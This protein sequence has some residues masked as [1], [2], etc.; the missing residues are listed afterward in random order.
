MGPTIHCLTGLVLTVVAANDQ[1]RPLS[2][3]AHS[4]LTGNIRE[5]RMRGEVGYVA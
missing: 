1:S 4:T 5:F 2:V 3:G